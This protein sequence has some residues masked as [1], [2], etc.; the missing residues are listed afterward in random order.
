M[1]M[2]G[3][4]SW[5]YRVFTNMR[6]YRTQGKSQS[7]EIDP[8]LEAD[9]HRNPVR[10]GNIAGSIFDRKDS[11]KSLLSEVEVDAITG[12]WL[13]EINLATLALQKQQDPELGYESAFYDC[14]AQAI[15]QVAQ[16]AIKVVSNAGGLN[17]AALCQKV[18]QLVESRGYDLRVVYVDGDDLIDDFAALKQKGEVFTN[19]DNGEPF[20]EMFEPIAV[21]A[22]LG[23]WGIAAALAN[24]ADIVITGRVTDAAPVIGVA[25]WWHQWQRNDYDALAGALI[26]GHLVECSNYVTGGNFP[27]FKHIGAATS[28]GY[29]VAEIAADGMTVITK[30]SHTDGLVSRE[31]V[32]TQLV[33]ELQGRY[34]LN[35]DVTADITHIEI[36][37]AGKNR[38]VVSGVKGIAPPPRA[39]VG[40][41]S[42]G[43]YAAEMHWYL[44]GLDIN[45]KVAMFKAQALRYLDPNRFLQLRF[46]AYGSVAEQPRNQREATVHL[47]VFAQA[48]DKDTLSR[49]NFLLPLLNNTMQTYP[50]A[51]CNYDVRLAEPRAF[52]EYWPCLLDVNKVAHRVHMG[53]QEMYDI[54]PASET[55]EVTQDS[56]NPAVAYDPSAYGELIEAPLGSIVFARSGDKF[57]NSNVGFFV[58][59]KDEWE[60]LRSFLSIATLRELLEEDDIGGV[61]ERVEFPEIQAVHF[62]NRG[63]LGKGV[64]S[65]ASYDSLGKNV[66]E[67][68]RCKRVNIPA[69]FL[70]RGLI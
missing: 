3:A 24:G 61:I 21:N 6:F 44:V 20:P 23:G 54:A 46:D 41:S 64:A 56:E 70:A 49:E 55:R 69:K 65:T 5:K 26:A 2:L 33:Y 19:L 57:T 39:K 12:D 68:L 36:Q 9:M 51:T 62:L 22:Y 37:D 29:P 34:Y 42:I 63:L 45:E 66:A 30:G 13:S 52:I 35:P 58:R 16:R 25:A 38:V 18:Q 31:T 40:I 43:G 10:I 7:H 15:D 59:N 67:Y 27:G 48:R 1:S 50:G 8:L 4:I 11:L 14:P 32:I 17:P 28:L 47:R 53:G 60:W